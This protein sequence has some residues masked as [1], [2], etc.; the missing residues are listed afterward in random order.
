M[1]ILRL[2]KTTIYLPDRLYRRAKAKA[3]LENKT[4]RVFLAE[5]IEKKLHDESGVKE[6]R[7]WIDLLPKVPPGAAADISD[8]VRDEDFREVDEG[9]WR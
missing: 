4:M 3:A 1:S 9:M 6:S 5:A 8:I 2:M 7:S